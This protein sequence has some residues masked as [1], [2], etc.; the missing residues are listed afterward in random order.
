[1]FP[2]TKRTYPD[3]KSYDKR[4]PATSRGSSPVTDKNGNVPRYRF[5]ANENII[6]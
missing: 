3:P 6:E 4:L 2:S 5:D 1:M